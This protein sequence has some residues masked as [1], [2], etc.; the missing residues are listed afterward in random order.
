METNMWDKIWSMVPEKLRSRKLFAATVGTYLTSASEQL[1][2]DLDPQVKGYMLMALWVA[3]I[4]VQG[5]VDAIKAWKGQPEAGDET[6]DKSE[7]VTKP[8]A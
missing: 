7:A 6:E 2:I 8:A 4:V 1:H 5:I 3:Y